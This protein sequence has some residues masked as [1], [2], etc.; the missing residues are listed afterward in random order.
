MRNQTEEMS[1][2]KISLA[3][4]MYYL[5]NMSQQEIA[6]RLQVSRP[7]VS[8]LLKRARDT[9]IVRIEIQSPLSGVPELE[10]RI[11][12]KYKVENIHVI[13]PSVENDHTSVS[14][15]AASYL[16]SCIKN[17]D[18]IGISWGM[19]ISRMIEYVPEMD[20]PDVRIVPVVGGAGSDAAILSNTNASRLAEVLHASC[21]LLHA[22]AC[23]SELREREVLLLNPNIRNILEE[24][25]KADIALLGIG[26]LE[27]SR[28]LDSQY[29]TDRDLKQM[30]EEGVVGDIAFRFLCE[31]GAIAPIDFNRRVVGCDLAALRK[32]AREVIAI[33]YGKEKSGIIRAS[34]RS[35]LITTL[36]TDDMTAESLL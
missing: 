7:W 3:A 20:F 28:I 11:R 29:T 10:D 5:C 31:D 12:E 13:H 33:A 22:N 17:K 25:E 14:M 36:F 30:R 34:L 16:V 15:A 24:G 4:E 27:H 9:G 6:A 18:T 23:C 26:D 2:R 21:T 35:R 32:N 1:A 8:K 19:S